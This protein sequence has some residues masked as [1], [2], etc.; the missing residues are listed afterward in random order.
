MTFGPNVS[1]QTLCDLLNERPDLVH[2]P[3]LTFFKMFMSKFAVPP[4]QV[5]PE[6]VAQ[7]QAVRAAAGPTRA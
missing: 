6:H 1:A 7:A 3:N 4:A 5:L 2:H